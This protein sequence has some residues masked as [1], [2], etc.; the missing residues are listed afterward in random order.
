MQ[1]HNY[2]R[3][4]NTVAT[5]LSH[6]FPNSISSEV[7][8]EGKKYC[9]ASLTLICMQFWLYCFTC[10]L[11][12]YCALFFFSLFYTVCTSLGLT[13]GH[14]IAFKSDSRHPPSCKL[15]VSVHCG[16][17]LCNWVDRELQWLTRRWIKRGVFKLLLG[18]FKALKWTDNNEA[19]FY[20]LREPGKALD[21][22]F[23]PSQKPEYQWRFLNGQV[24]LIA[25]LVLPQL[26]I[27]VF[28]V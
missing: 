20:W 7:K 5:N 15:V 11:G 10:I 6:Y 19:F 28:F 8:Y 13:D 1:Q 27:H 9:K 17:E 26:Q 2:R 14:Q 12:V 25:K 16:V 24:S 3:V 21:W 4:S 22:F 23:Y 18:K